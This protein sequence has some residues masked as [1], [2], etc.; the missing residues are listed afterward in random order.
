MR[1]VVLLIVFGAAGLAGGQ[2]APERAYCQRATAGI[3][4]GEALSDLC[5]FAVTLQ[6]RLPN[7]ICQ[8]TIKSY[9]GSRPFQT[10]TAEVRHED[11][12][13]T[14]SNV[15][16]NGKP[17]KESMA[18]LPGSWTEGEFGSV[19]SFI[20]GE[21][22]RS[23]F[24][25]E[26]ETQWRSAPALLFEFELAA[27]NNHAWRVEANGL[28]VLPG[29]RGKVWVDAASHELRRVEMQA[30]HLN[31]LKPE[32]RPNLTI[33]RSSRKPIFLL[34]S[35]KISVDYAKQLLGDGSEFILPTESEDRKC[36]ISGTCIRDQVRFENCHKFGAKARIVDDVTD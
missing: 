1:C 18:H 28:E 30:E 27:E 33:Q 21:E 31:E 22:S 9:V 35:L 36:L 8:R 24:R 15:M 5:E 11:G 19:V 34:E 4:H 10:I 16:R 20:F 17:F 23:R 7:V 29:F 12:R 26:K 3:Q 14:Y 13:D 25:F 2:V 6:R 32:E